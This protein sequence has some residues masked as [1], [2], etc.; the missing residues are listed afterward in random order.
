MLIV[1]DGWKYHV[2]PKVISERFHQEYIFL[3]LNPSKTHA[4]VF[5]DYFML[6]IDTLDLRIVANESIGI[7]ISSGASLQTRAVDITETYGVLVGISAHP[8]VTPFFTYGALLVSLNSS[9][10]TSLKPMYTQYRST[11]D[12]FSYS[13]TND[14]SISINP[15]RHIAVVGVPALNIVFLLS[16]NTSSTAITEWNLNITRY[17][18]GPQYCT[19]FGQSVLW[20]DDVTV[21]ITILKVPNRPWSQSEVWIFDVDKPFKK[22]LFTFPNNQQNM[23]MPSLPIF[24]QTLYFSGNLGIVT[25]QNQFLLVPS[26]PTGFVSVWF[27][28][29]VEQILIFRSMMCMPGTYK[30]T[31]DFGPC[32]ICPPQTKNPGV[33]PCSQCESCKATSFCPL[34]S[35]GDVS[36]NIYPSY[37]QT[38]SYPNTP[39]TNNYDDLLVQNTFTIGDS[40][41]CIAISPIFWTTIVI[42]L[43]F[44]I[45]LVMNLSKLCKCPKADLHR[46]NAKQFFQ[47][48]DIINEGESWIGGLFSFAILLLFGFTFWFASNFLNLYPTETSSLS[49]VSCDSVI[50][51]AVLKSAL[52][53]PLPNP[54][55]SRWVVF[56]MLDA[57]PFTMTIDL[58]NT[59]ADCLSITAQENRAGLDFVRL[60]ITSCILQLDNITR[61]ISVSLP[62][63]HT[64][65]Q[66]N[67]TGPVFVGGMRLCLYGPGYVNTVYKLQILD[68][69][70]V[71]STTNETLSRMTSLHIIMV[72]VVNVTKP[73]TVGDDTYYSGRW[74]PTFVDSSVSDKLIYEQNGEYLRYQSE[75]TIL[76]ITLSEHPFYLQNVQQPIVRRAELAFHTL[77]FCTL[78]IELFSIG[79]L[80]FRLI[81]KPVFYSVLRWYHH[82]T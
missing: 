28:N 33:E 66:V 31:S 48:L 76:I 45:W 13:H 5:A 69:C 55:G 60:S 63:H 32:T 78:I 81:V 8:D 17:E 18:V 12:I 23:I 1:L 38:F 41:R 56:D 27:T 34:G 73:L 64:S 49:H 7:D 75:R 11:A 47:K 19:G 15:R 35:T 39:D 82:D 42:T 4:Y 21:A 3:K 37:Q 46:K 80:S 57:Q 77:L 74:A 36:I 29:N 16:I 20:I 30:N 9:Q 53:L 51:N 22:P 72:K 70:Q 62:S 58:F 50:N 79:F 10:T 25:D 44:I 54:D 14:M 6:T 2:Q 59:A 43:C 71:F 52:Q 65:V 24:F 40:P 61:S 68:M 67:I 26:Q